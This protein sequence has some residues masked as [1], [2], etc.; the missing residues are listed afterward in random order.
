MPTFTD[1][2][3]VHIHYEAHRVD[4]PSAVIQLA[5]GVGEHIGRYRE[6]I[7]AL[8]EAG[9]SVWADDHRGHG[10][11][12]FEQHGGDLDRIGRLGPGGLRATIAAVE[13]FTDVIRE[14]EGDEVPLVLLGHSWGSLMAQIILNRSA[15]RYDGAVLTGTAY[16]TLRWM[17]PGERLNRRHRHLGTTG[18]EWLSRDPAVAEAFVADPY[19]TLTPLRRL[20]GT[21]D[22]MRLLG[23]PAPA[24]AIPSELPL[25][26]MVGSD[27]TLG[28]EESARR[29]AQAY[30]S[31]SGLVDVEVV[32]YADARHE[33]FNELNRLEVRDDLIGW[34][35]ERFAV[36]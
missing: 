22:A 17:D 31:R 20:F 6:L 26:I 1:A 28:G 34:L 21:I 13:Q 24:P 25:L 15:V 5:H 12:G 11:T 16:R 29:L 7:A 10:R 33:V 8:N 23:R 2:Y 27:D 14:A 4:D 32:V 30:V 9:Y 35:D 18:A 3:G 36:D 19:T